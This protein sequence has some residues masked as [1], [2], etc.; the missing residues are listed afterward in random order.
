MRG[1]CGASF[2]SPL[3]LSAR[4]FPSPCSA[5]LAPPAIVLVAPKSFLEHG[6]DDVIRVA[7]DKLCVIIKQSADGFLDA[8]FASHDGRS[9]LNDRH[10]CLLGLGIHNVF[11]SA[12]KITG[13]E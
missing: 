7:F 9:F 10:G 12:G 8:H 5:R 13:T 11:S 3:D 2:T 6:I 1:S 4:H